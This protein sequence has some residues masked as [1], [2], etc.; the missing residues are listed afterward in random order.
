MSYV[1][2]YRV[3]NGTSGESDNPLV[4]FA[5]RGRESE[6]FIG[7]DSKGKVR[8]FCLADLADFVNK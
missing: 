6:T 3:A 7:K 5:V 1:Q 4:I 2:N 8:T